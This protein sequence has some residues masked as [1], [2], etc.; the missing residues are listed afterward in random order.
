MPY[1]DQSLPFSGRSNVSRH[2]SWTGARAAVETRA[3]K[4]KVYAAFLKAF[5]PKTDQAAAAWLEYPLSSICSIRN[6]LGS[7]VVASGH[8]THVQGTRSTKRTLWRWVGV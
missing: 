1:T 6:G 8:E 7:L 5:G 2:S 4:T 3:E